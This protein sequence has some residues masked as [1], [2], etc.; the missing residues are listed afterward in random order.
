[1]L[2]RAAIP[3]HDACKA[4]F[5]VCRNEPNGIHAFPCAAF[6]Q[7]RH[8]PNDHILWVFCRPLHG[9]LLH[10]RH[11]KRMRD[12]IERFERSRIAK[13]ACGK[14]A[15]VQGTAGRKDFR[16]KRFRKQKKALRP[17]FHDLARND[18]SIEHMR[19]QSGKPL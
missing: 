13:H 16:A 9:K 4:R 2:P 11:D 19:A 18:I 12:R 8:I 7:K 10:P 5:L 15:P 14:R 17:G 1:M 3:C 6:D